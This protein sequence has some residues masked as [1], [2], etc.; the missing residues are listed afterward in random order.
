M[1]INSAV[2]SFPCFFFCFL[3]FGLCELLVTVSVCFV[4]FQNIYI[5]SHTIGN[6]LTRVDTL[7]W[8]NLQTNE[9]AKMV[10]GGSV[11]EP[12]FGFE[13]IIFHIFCQYS[14]CRLLFEYNFGNTKWPYQMHSHPIS[15]HKRHRFW[16]F[17][18][19]ILRVVKGLVTLS[20]THS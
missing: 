20:K 14:F 4:L 9:N 16:I 13:R 18:S 7:R 2:C 15:K 6:R 3:S 19:L 10:N 11:N 12:I 8:L 5:C 1:D 17:F